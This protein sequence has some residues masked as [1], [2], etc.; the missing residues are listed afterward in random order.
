MR[1]VQLLETLQSKA[2]HSGSCGCGWR[3]VIRILQTRSSNAVACRDCSLTGGHKPA[4]TAPLDANESHFRRLKPLA[5]TTRAVR[6]DSKSFD[7]HCPGRWD[8]MCGNCYKGYYFC[9]DTSSVAQDPIPTR[10]RFLPCRLCFP[11]VW[12]QI[13][14]TG[15]RSLPASG[16]EEATLDVGFAT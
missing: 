13:C 4:A 7:I 16:R 3:E 2:K 8:C 9:I 10:M 1:I 6:D 11:W 14:W 12:I 15:K 5:G